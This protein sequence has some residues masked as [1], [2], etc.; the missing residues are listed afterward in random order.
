V[1]ADLEAEPSRDRRL[2]LL[3][4]RVHEFL[5]MP[6]VEA[7]DVVVVRPLVQLEDRHAVREVMPRDETRRLELGEHSIHGGE[8]DI[9]AQLGKP[10]VDVLG[11]E[12]AGA[13]ALEDVEDLHARQRD[14]QSSLAQILAF[15]ERGVPLG[16]GGQGL[17]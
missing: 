13:T 2:S 3:D 17:E 16:F 15:H 5:H 4:A 11:R 8:T 1:L 12:V 10:A 7:E 14:L 9:L 6:A